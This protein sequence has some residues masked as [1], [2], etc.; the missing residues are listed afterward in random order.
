MK[1]CWTANWCF[2][3][4]RSKESITGVGLLANLFRSGSAGSDGILR[5]GIGQQREVAMRGQKLLATMVAGMLLL[6]CSGCG[7]DKEQKARNAAEPRSSG[8]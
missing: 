2:D 7:K 4:I 3:K 6:V 5:D 1:K 8:R